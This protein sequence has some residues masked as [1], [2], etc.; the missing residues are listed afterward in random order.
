MKEEQP[1]HLSF[2]ARKRPAVEGLIEDILGPTSQLNEIM[3]NAPWLGK[4]ID[5]DVGC[6]DEPEP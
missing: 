3:S 1:E 4:T 6:P 2:I 5:M